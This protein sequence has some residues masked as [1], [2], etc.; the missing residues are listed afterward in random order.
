VPDARRLRD[1]TADWLG[2]HVGIG[3]ADARAPACGLWPSERADTS[4]MVDKRLRAFAAGRA[5]AR[6]AMTATGHASADL[7]RDDR[8]APIWPAGLTG[9][10]T[11]SGGVAMALVAPT[12]RMRA[13]GLDL[14]EAAPLPHDLWADILT[15]AERARCPDGAAAKRIFSA[16][17][18]IYKAQYTITGGWLGFHD[19]EV[20]LSDTGFQAHILPDL[21]DVPRT[22]CGHSH[23]A[24]GLILS[25]VA[26]PLDAAQ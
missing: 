14:E 21:P 8:G 25:V 19:A 18:A 6:D 10:I 5:A 4:G 11:H 16:K 2:P 23:S 12:A 7:A 9:S 20:T 13:L 1:L 15:P 17:E 22:L 24:A 3:L 26:L